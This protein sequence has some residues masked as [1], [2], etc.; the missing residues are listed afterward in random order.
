[1]NIGDGEVWMAVAI[2][3]LV[4]VFMAALFGRWLLL[5]VLPAAALTILGFVE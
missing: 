3:V 4:V 1:M 2:N 5:L